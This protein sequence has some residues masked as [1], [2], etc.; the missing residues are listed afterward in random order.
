MKENII[1]MIYY[2]HNFSPSNNVLFEG[3]LFLPDSLIKS[4]DLHKD[5]YV[6]PN[7]VAFVKPHIRQGIGFKFFYEFVSNKLC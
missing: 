5:I 6:A 1:K 2:C 4:L 3:S 7:G